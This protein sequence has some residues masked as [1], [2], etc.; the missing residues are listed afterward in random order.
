MGPPGVVQGPG[1][2][3]VSSGVK[4]QQG[5]AS[6]GRD[7]A[8]E[9]A[10]ERLR[11]RTDELELIISSLTIFA[12][13]SIPGW[14]FNAF[15]DSYTHYSTH[16]AIA[17]TLLT[18]LIPGVCYGLG[19]C[20]VAHLM[21]RAY[22]V[23]LIG[24]RAAF[25]K[26]IDWSRT[27]TIGPVTRD[28]L[29]KTLPDPDDMIQRT[30]RVASSLFSVISMLTLMM[31][32]LGVIL[33]LALVLAGSAGSRF[34]ATNM[35]LGL[36]T[37]G[38]FIVFLGIPL[39]IY[40]LDALLASRLTFLQKSTVFRGT[41]A[42]LRGISG[43]AY[44]QRLV[45]PVQLTLQSNTRPLVFF[46]ATTLAV[47]GIIVVGQYRAAGWQ[48]FTLSGEFTYMTNDH[49]RAGFR[50]AHYE[51][52]PSPKDRLRPW[53]RISSFIQSGSTIQLFL[54]YHPLRDNLVLRA[55]CGDPGPRSEPLGGS[56]NDSLNCLRQLWTVRIAGQDVPMS[57]FFAAE[58]SDLGMRG[59]MGVVPIEG[60]SPGVH[61]L[62]VTW[63]PGLDQE[64]GE[65]DDRYPEDDVLYHIPFSFSPDYER[66]L[67]E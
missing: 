29:Q 7:Q 43:F 13:F 9:G 4:N 6:S 33:V 23:G 58:R 39:F 59:L 25:P 18:A 14:L 47:T 19:A 54:P 51:D 67:P 66:A 31:L 15:S 24:L 60:L 45:L 1:K 35:A 36:T 16:L 44:P 38:M 12:L 55:M 53:P 37:L 65:I 5:R 63:S 8:D 48:N 50:S 61:Q 64:L 56:L 34:G 32:W 49:V 52:I 2:R 62:E 17:G 21:V 42:L 46:V 41:V 30:D 11:D 28:H 10:L 57:G 22:W 27:P 3:E 20:F 26:G 40:L